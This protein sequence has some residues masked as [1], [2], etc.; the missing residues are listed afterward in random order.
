MEKVMKASLDRLCKDNSLGEHNP[1]PP[2]F[3]GGITHPFG[4][5]AKNYV[6][7]WQRGGRGDF[8]NM[9]LI[10]SSYF[11]I[12]TERRNW[13]DLYHTGVIDKSEYYRNIPKYNL[14]NQSYEMWNRAKGS[15][16]PYTQWMVEVS[17]GNK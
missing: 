9:L 3:K 11:S 1:L 8:I 5:R 16:Q 2:F 10:A 14:E 17:S 4:E 15:S 7:L 6:P 12:D 13:T